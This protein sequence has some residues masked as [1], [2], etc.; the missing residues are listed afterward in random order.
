MGNNFPKLE[1]E[2]RLQFEEVY[3][4]NK[5]IQNKSTSRLV[6]VKLHNTIDKKKNCN[7]QRKK[8]DDLGRM[9]RLTAD[10]SSAIV[11]VR[12]QWN[13]N[14]Q[15]LRENAFPPRILYLAKPSPSRTR[16]RS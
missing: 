7:Y 13:S 6:I 15:V 3:V 14:F 10:F 9:G 5:E 12:R 1:K 4:P 2:M 16:Q 8:V 11:A